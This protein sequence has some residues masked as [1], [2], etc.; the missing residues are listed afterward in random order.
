V[1]L[2]KVTKIFDTSQFFEVRKKGSL[3]G[4][5]LTLWRVLLSMFAVEWAAIA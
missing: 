4:Y 1:N 5:N 3:C 2:D